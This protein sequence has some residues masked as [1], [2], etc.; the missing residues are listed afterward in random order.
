MKPIETLTDNESIALLFRLKTINT[1]H[2]RK[3]HNIRD[4][5]IALLMLDAGLRVGEVCRL[6]ICDL[7]FSGREVI[8][9]NLSRDIAEKRCERIIPMSPRLRQAVSEMGRIVWTTIPIEDQDYAF[10]VNDCHKAISARQ[11]QQIISNASEEAIG[12]KI[13]PHIL[14]HT[15]A[16]KL[17]RVTSIRIVQQLLGH[18]NLASTQ[19][20]TH[21][22]GEDLKKA[23]D[24][25][26]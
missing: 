13:H 21:P 19:V 11:I 14:R 25:I 3:W 18:K 10:F 2:W 16:T 6:K 5:T 12:R 7:W 17:M 15:F 20:Y 8:S 24:A 9:L 22:N 23:I 1:N 26:C 4:Y